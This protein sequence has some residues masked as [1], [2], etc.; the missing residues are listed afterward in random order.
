MNPFDE[1][2]VE[3]AVR[4]KE[5][6]VAKEVVAVS[7]GPT[8][9][10]ETLRT[11]L[12]MGADRGIHV[13]IS[14]DDYTA[15]QPFHISKIL[16]KLALE[17]KADILLLGKQAI[18]DD[19]NQTG[20]MAAALLDWPQ[21][22]FACKVE[23]SNA[24]LTVTRE[25]D[26]GL[27]TLKMKT[28]CV[29]TTDLRLNEPRYA[30]LPNIMKAKKKPIAKKS[31]ADYGVD[32]TPRHTVLK[33]DDPPTR[34]AGEK[35]E[36]VED[37][38]SK[39]KEA[40]FYGE[41]TTEDKYKRTLEEMEALKDHMSTRRAMARRSQSAS[42]EWKARML[43]AE[44]ELREQKDEHKAVSSDITRQYKTMQTD[45]GLRIYTLET[46]LARTRAQ[47][48]RTELELKQ[49]QEEKE[50]INR[51]KDQEIADL[52][53]KKDNMEQQYITIID[54]TLDGLKEKIGIARDKWED[55]SNAIQS[56]NKHLLLEFGLN[57]LHI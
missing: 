31:A 19:C 4:M 33:V 39:L 28:P 22:T 20:Q 54:R 52:K 15:V 13:E 18:D 16:A 6:K 51:D 12:A 23:E 44:G 24:N 45:M 34:A 9:C 37:L 40:G 56:K 11:A 41:L 49:T 26:G 55:K 47:L 42:D 38:V 43:Q 53:L 8:Q 10:Q 3:E 50:K 27:E 25:V 1:I 57:P 2:A 46:E 30:T 7:C 48:D 5:K 17:E 29:V 32:L 21:A 36:T 35:L 14:G